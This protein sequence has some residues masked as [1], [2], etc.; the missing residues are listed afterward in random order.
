MKTPRLGVVMDPIETILPKK[1]STLA[2]LLAAQKRGWSVA[3]MDVGDLRL[4]DGRA[5]ATMRTLQVFDDTQHWFEAGEGVDG[6]L[7]DLD[8]V[9]MRKDPPFNLEYIAATYVLERAEEEG[10][11][12][13]NRPR[14]LRDAN[15]KIF[16][17]WFPQCCPPTLITCSMPA[18]RSFHA[19]HGH[20]VVKPI[21]LMGGRSVFVVPPGDMNANVIFEE[22]TA[23]GRRFVQ[24]QAY[25]SEIAV[26][27]DKRILLIDGEPV[28]HVLAR[29]PAEGE[30][31]AN[32]AAGGRAVGAAL[33]ERDRWICQQIG[34]A[35][36]ERGLTFVGIDVIGDWLTEVN[37]TS[38]TGIR[39]L[40]KVFDL[41]VAS[42]LLDVI[43]RKWHAAKR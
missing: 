26:T 5:E 22:V 25:I 29:M 32:M 4:R 36:R 33:T 11:L 14:S 12:V 15:E 16:A 34:P 42:T 7:G 39:E 31:R 18:L 37:V 24:A 3:G 9:L 23:R 41:D 8:I 1:D 21:D 20:I 19:E 28:P 13:V 17:S 6:R 38:P 30:A 43:E 2:M 40:D 10:V 35:L 27:G